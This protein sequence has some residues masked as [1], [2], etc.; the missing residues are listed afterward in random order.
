[1]TV[2][3]EPGTV[4]VWFWAPPLLHPVQTYCVPAGPAEGESACSVCVEPTA[5]LNVAGVVVAFPSTLTKFVPVGLEVMV[6]EVAVA[7]N[8]AEPEF[9][10]ASVAV[11]VFKPPFE[12]TGTLNVA[13]NE[14]VLF[15]VTVDGDVDCAM[16]LYVIVIVED[17]AKFDPDTVTVVPT[18]PL[19]GKMVIVGV[20]VKRAEAVLLF[21][22]LSVADTT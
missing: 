19:V 5:Q 9:E 7:M 22:L 11:T 6:I 8:V 15:E 16:P 14:P 2:A 3:L 4:Y 13:V 10:L 21:M 18:I 20:R 12:V 1:V 17:G